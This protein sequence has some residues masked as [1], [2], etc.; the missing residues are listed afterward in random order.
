MTKLFLTGRHKD[1]I[2]KAGRNL[3][4]HEAEDIAAATPGVRKGCVAAFG[5]S[6]PTRGTERFVIVAETRLTDAKSRVALE[7]TIIE[8]VS[9]SL[10]VPPDVVVLSPPGSVLKTSSGKIRRG[11]TREVYLTGR[12]QK[13]HRSVLL[14]WTRLI[15]Q[16]SRGHVERWCHQVNRLIFTGWVGILLLLT[17]PFLWS[18]LALGP[19]GS[20][21]NRVVGQLTRLLF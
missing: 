10:G 20:W 9:T 21:V 18:A 8:R 15:L 4:P 6:D 16:A 19:K 14:Q 17:V 2:I 5:V 7:S 11:A 12:L 3:Q 1:L 13:Q